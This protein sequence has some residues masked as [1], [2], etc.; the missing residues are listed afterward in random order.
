[1]KIKGGCIHCK[2]K[3]DE[4]GYGR[5]TYKTKTVY[6]HRVC[7]ALAHPKENILNKIIHH[8]C[9]NGFCVNPAHL[10]AITRKQHSAEHGLSG[11]AKIHA[12]KTHC[13]NGHLLD[14]KNN[15]QRFCSICR[16]ISANKWARKAYNENPEKYKEIAKK[17]R[18]SDEVKKRMKE[19]QQEWINKN[20][21][22]MNEYQREY[23]HKKKL[24]N[25]NI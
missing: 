15:K 2:S 20:R 17:Y 4:K 14:R 18:K 3:V 16:K 5:M 22:Y 25:K 24:L 13:K 1:M 9:R 6:E 23:L 10:I 21:Y 11:W 12:E 7:Y 19:Y 8:I